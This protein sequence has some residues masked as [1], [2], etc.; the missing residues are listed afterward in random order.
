MV[1]AGLR[2]HAAADAGRAGAAGPRAV[3]GA[4]ADARRPWP[5]EPR[6]RGG[7]DVGPARL[8]A[9][10]AAAARRRHRHRRAARRRGAGR[11]TTTCSRCRA[12]ATTPRRR[13]R[14]SPSA[15]GTSSS[16]PTC[17]GCWPACVGGRRVPAGL[18]DPGRARPGRA[19][20]CPTTTRTPPRWSVARHGAR[21]AGVHRRA[22]RAARPARSRD[23]CAW[24]RGRL[25]GVRRSAA[26]RP[27]L[28]RHR[29]A[30]PRPAAG[31]AAR[32][33][34]AGAPP[35]LDG[36]VGRR[37]AARALPATPDR[38]RPGRRRPP[39]TRFALP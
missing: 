5:R 25:P 7:A 10:G 34:R 17:A 19:R 33:R 36:R 28:G 20:C 22:A 9:P 24:R 39:P 18:G 38:R 16:T 26:P 30:V 27:G 21:R 14:P 13:S 31:R 35:R 29:P 6:R 1:G 2:V 37:D 12:S 8:P 3:A 11:P 15:G 4:L 23:Q 32:R